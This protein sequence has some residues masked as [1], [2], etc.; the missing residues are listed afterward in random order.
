MGCACANRQ[1]FK[2]VL[3][4]APERSCCPSSEVTCK[5]GSGRYPGS[6]VREKS[7]PTTK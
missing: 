6:I 1:K 2:I 5:A 4:G 7:A 3:E